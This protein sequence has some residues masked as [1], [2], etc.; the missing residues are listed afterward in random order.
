MY[1]RLAKVFYIFLYQVLFQFCSYRND[2]LKGMSCFIKNKV[3][4]KGL[5]IIHLHVSESLQVWGIS[6]KTL[7]QFVTLRYSHLDQSTTMQSEAF[8]LC[9]CSETSLEGFVFLLITL[10]VFSSLST[11]HQSPCLLSGQGAWSAVIQPN[12]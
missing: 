1:V 11:D 12:P 10:T 2:S 8:Y 9:F 4:E 6:L 7:H 5:K 3:F